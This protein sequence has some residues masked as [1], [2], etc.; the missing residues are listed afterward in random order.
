MEHRRARC[1]RTLTRG[2]SIKGGFNY[3]VSK[4]MVE[5]SSTAG[6]SW[7]SANPIVFDPNNPALAYSSN[8]PGKR[9]FLAA[10]YTAP[11]LR[12]RR[13]HVLGVLRRPHQR[14]HQLRL[15]GRRQRRH[16]G[17]QRPD[18]HP[19]RHVGDELQAA[20][21]RAAEPTP[22]PIRPRRSSSSFRADKYLQ[23]A[24]RPVRGA[25]RGVPADGP[26]HGPQR[27]ARTCSRTSAAAGTPARSASTSRTSATC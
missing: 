1:R 19:A 27:H 11:V 18:L 24:S 8:S 25:Q 14:Q 2:F 13:D 21:R 5:P 7:G 16:R 9:I 10:N 22:P 6:S 20:D 12:V 26:P 3:G 23:L 15:L 4:S 17:G